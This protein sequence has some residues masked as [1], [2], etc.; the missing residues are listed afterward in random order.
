MREVMTVE[1]VSISR[2][3]VPELL[4]HLNEVL[5]VLQDAD[6]ALVAR[7]LALPGLPAEARPIL[8]EWSGVRNDIHT[9]SDLFV[10]G[11]RGD[12]AETIQ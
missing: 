11:L 7:L 3:R 1:Q 4:K 2:E 5:N 10:I 12:V 9:A 6:N 8:K